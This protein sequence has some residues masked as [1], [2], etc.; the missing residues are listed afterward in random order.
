MNTVNKFFDG[1]RPPDLSVAEIERLALL[2]EELGEAQQIIGKILR[3]GYESYNPFDGR[4]I[5]NRSL[6]E[7]EL[8][9]VSFAMEL[10]F[11]R[12][13][14]NYREVWRHR[15]EKALTVQKYL[16]HNFISTK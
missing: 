9:D 5:I 8:G 1:K 7:N 11:A 15:D 4:K 2:T 13:D 16:H 6:L 14:I 12:N 10:M 3:H